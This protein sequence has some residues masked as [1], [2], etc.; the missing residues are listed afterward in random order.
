MYNN[1][2]YEEYMRT[3]LGYTPRTMQDTFM[4]NDYYIMQNNNCLADDL[5]PDMYKKV[6]PLV[7]KECNTNTMPIT[8]EILEQMTDNV[9]NQIEIDLKIQTNVKV[10]TRDGL[11]N[12]DPKVEDINY[13]TKE[14]NSKLQDIN[15]KN[16]DVS[17][18]NQEISRNRQES[19]VRV[20]GGNSV[21]KESIRAQVS[22]AQKENT[23][24]QVTNT[25]SI[26][27]NVEDT[28]GEDR[29]I[30]NNT[31]RDLI[32]ILILRELID[33]GNFPG[34]PP[35]FPGRP[36]MRRTTPTI[37]RRN[38]TTIYWWTTEGLCQENFR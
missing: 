27:L 4:A 3:V 26:N 28:R 18:K 24:T 33:N 8:R 10:E 5:Y 38:K 23:R 6:Y 7:C 29:N 1:T 19:N 17:Y 14:S 35:H 30:R 11:R 37:S 34:R 32:K 15:L 21:Q 16:R 25:Q 22:P 2:S 20:Q 36:P 12:L 31:L 9:L 13:R